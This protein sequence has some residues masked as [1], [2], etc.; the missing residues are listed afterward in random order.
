MDQDVTLLTQNANLSIRI[1]ELQDHGQH[2]SYGPPFR[3]LW[4]EWDCNPQKCSPLLS[5]SFMTL[6]CTLVW[7]GVCWQIGWLHWV[8]LISQIWPIQ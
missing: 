3:S 5:W 8:L 1:Q 7:Q 2:D 4:K 6:K